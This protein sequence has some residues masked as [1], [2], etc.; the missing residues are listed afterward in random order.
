MTKR[1]KALNIIRYEYATHGKETR[2]CMR[3]YIE[4]RV[5]W[6]A[7]CKAVSEGLKIYGGKELSNKGD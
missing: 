7:R 5:S 3:A 2:D 6:E 1:E 4:N